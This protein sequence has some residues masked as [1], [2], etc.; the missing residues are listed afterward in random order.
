[1]SKILVKCMHGIGDTIYARPFVQMLVNDGHD[2]YLETPL[3]FMFDDLRV[4][5]V[6][7]AT[8]Y[9]T[10]TKAL[11]ESH[12]SLSERP[13]KIDVTVDYFYSSDDLRRHGIVTHLEQA[14]GYEPGSTKPK[15]DLPRTL[16]RHRLALPM[17]KP[18]VVVRPV[19]QRTEWMCSARSPKP[20]Y[21]AWCAK[22]LHDMG[23]YVISI[24]DTD[25]VNEWI[26]PEG[27]P[28]AD[29]KLHSGELGLSKTLSLL[30]DA[31]LAIGGSGF[32]VPAAIAAKVPLFIIFGGR[33]GYDNPHKILDLRMNL[34]KVGWALP[35]N[36]CR[37][38]SMDHDCDK[39]IPD[40]DS[41][42][43]RFMRDVL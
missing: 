4:K 43:L 5:V 30:E 8:K 19:T 37:C 14:F 12:R 18:I 23:W 20:N 40:L 36:F 11:R 17:D 9:R 27:D 25:D 16:P 15:F 1:M 13:E 41:Q 31:D 21:I 39:E 38:I 35:S 33:G 22:I 24:A 26:E 7:T 34:K 6:S 28:V 10:Q 2:V 29:L 32:I 42:F 3:P